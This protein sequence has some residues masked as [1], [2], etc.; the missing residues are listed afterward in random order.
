MIYLGEDGIIVKFRCE[1]CDTEL[2]SH[3]TYCKKY[4]DEYHFGTLL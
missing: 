3:K 4:G 2:K 1:K